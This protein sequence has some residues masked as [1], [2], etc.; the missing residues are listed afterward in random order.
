MSSFS[1]RHG[2]R[3]TT[4]QITIRED[5]PSNLRDALPLI[6]KNAG[7]VPSAM[8]NAICEI[9][10]VMPNL[11]NWADYPN[12]WDEVNS[13]IKDAPWYR[14]YDIAE[15]FYA[16]LAEQWRWSYKPADKFE[17]RLNEFFIENGIGWELRNGEI[18]HR[19]SETFAKSAHETPSR[20]EEGGFQRAANELREA[21]ADISRRPEPDI[22]G[23]MQHAMAALETTAREVA[24]QPNLTLGQLV[25]RLDLPQPLDQAVKKLWGYASER[26][27]HIREGESVDRSEAELVVSIAGSLCDFLAQRRS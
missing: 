3:P 24:S 22:T 13:L 2:Y 20:L 9:L 21:L 10:L 11:S 8:R 23:A 6:A 17:Q 7:M 19:G 16:E 18:V 1:D 12:V 4:T 26:G 27:R 14:V 5:A 15:A 25:L